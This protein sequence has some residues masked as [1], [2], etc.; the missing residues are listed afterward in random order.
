V[1]SVLVPG[2]F[3]VIFIVW[4][5]AVVWW[6]IVLIGALRLPDEA[7]VDA[8]QSKMLW[9]LLMVFLGVIGTILYVVIV[10]PALANTSPKP[11]DASLG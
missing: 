11:P 10:R 6:L 5:V 2:V 4:L 1:D 8:G 7:W 9:V 3:G